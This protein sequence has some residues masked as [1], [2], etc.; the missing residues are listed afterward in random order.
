VTSRGLTAG[1]GVLY[2]VASTVAPLVLKTTP[3]D[4]DLYLWPEAQ[5]IAGGHPLLIYATY[6]HALYQNDNGPLGLIPLVPVVAIAN[7]LGWAG[8]LTGRAALA[9][10]VASLFVLLLSYQAVRF[11][12]A[13]RGDARWPLAIAAT[14]LLAPALWIAVLDYG[15]VEQPVELCF[16]LF[17]ITCSL[18]RR[19]V[20]S[21]VAFGAAIL[22]R[23]I[24][25]FCLIPIVVIDVAMRRIRAAATIVLATLV[26]VGVGIMPFVL[27]NE[28]AVTHALLTYRASL[29]IG[30]GSFWIVARGA[31]WAGV[32]RSADVYVGAA[33][34]IALV[35]LMVWRRPLIGTT[36]AG[37][38]GLVT[39]ASCC[40]PLFAKTAFPYYLFEPYVFAVLWWLARPGTSFNWR[41]VVPLLLTV[42][43]FIVMAATAS[44]SSTVGVAESVIASVVVCA[45]IALVMLDL[46]REPSASPAIRAAHETA[47]PRSIPVT[48]DAQ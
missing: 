39:I 9:G 12:A 41:V 25:G 7:A 1:L 14:V 15:H 35:A 38:I 16:V 26:T 22:A 19:D 43:V 20:L 23:T 8:S 46:L 10:G 32:V 28:P 47:H 3:S 5:V 37:M 17:A 18:H 45:C 30:G 21:G 48:Q 6:N 34:A 29:P 13:A 11:T 2:V 44:P 40:V 27:A 33:V 4:L 36:H 31:S 42:D 24:A